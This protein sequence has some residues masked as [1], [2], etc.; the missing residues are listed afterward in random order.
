MRKPMHPV[1]PQVRA[2]LRKDGGGQSDVYVRVGSF[3]PV[4]IMCF[5]TYL[6]TCFRRV[7]GIDSSDSPKVSGELDMH[8][9]QTRHRWNGCQ[10]I[11]T[12]PNSIVTMGFSIVNSGASSRLSAIFSDTT[13]L[14]SSVLSATGESAWA[15]V[16]SQ[17][18]NLLKDL[19]PDCD[20][21]VAAD[22]LYFMASNY[23]AF[24]LVPE[25][26]V[27]EELRVEPLQ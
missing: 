18:G 24:S 4:C 7:N 16:A 27:Q 21:L 20:G 1:S 15:P 23:S 11:V 26:D 14:T 5:V 8:S 19:F 22:G 9:G 3:L 2:R 10:A 17:A 6:T 12:T 25:P 13:K